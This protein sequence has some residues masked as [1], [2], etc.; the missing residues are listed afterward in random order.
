MLKD[1]VM[2]KRSMN[3][4]THYV[5]WITKIINTN[6]IKAISLMKRLITFIL[7]FMMDMELQGKKRLH[8]L[9]ILFKH[10]LKKEF[11]QLIE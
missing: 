11:Q 2:E 6:R 3:N 9:V 1:K 4:K 8:Q 7:L 10:I 5:L